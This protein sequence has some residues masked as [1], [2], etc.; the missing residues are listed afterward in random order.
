MATGSF[1]ICTGKHTCMYTELITAVA[2]CSLVRNTQRKGQH[3]LVLESERP[4]RRTWP[5]LHVQ[6][7]FARAK[8][9]VF[10]LLSALWSTYHFS[11]YIDSSRRD[12]SATAVTVTNQGGRTILLVSSSWSYRCTVKSW[13][14]FVYCTWYWYRFFPNKQPSASA[15]MIR[16]TS[17][18]FEVRTTTMNSVDM[19][20]QFCLLVVANIDILGRRIIVLY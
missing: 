15:S 18:V 3:V 9:L 12:C 5:S 2:A 20:A 1:C 4:H 10:L 17:H 13:R 7:Q 16:S 6:S 14:I 19:T 11:S 8:S